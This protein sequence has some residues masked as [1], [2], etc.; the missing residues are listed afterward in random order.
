MIRAK[1]ATITERPWLT[2][3]LSSSITEAGAKRGCEKKFATA[4]EFRPGV[5]RSLFSSRESF[6]RGPNQEYQNDEFLVCR[7]FAPFSPQALEPFVAAVSRSCKGRS[8]SLQNVQN[9]YPGLRPFEQEDSDFFFG[10]ESH[11]EE[12]LRRL[13][14]AR[15]V[16]VVGTSGSG[17]SSL[18]R[19]GLIP[20]L[21]GDM[22]A[23]GSHW[24]IAISGRVTILSRPWRASC[25]ERFL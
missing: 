13:G 22:S 24:S 16:A 25:T 2:V 23:A 5:G 7:N 3:M 21:Y 17:K 9:P 4:E 8:M 18:V 1:S 19:A 6:D 20:A 15:F 11:T 12:L 14:S 10:R